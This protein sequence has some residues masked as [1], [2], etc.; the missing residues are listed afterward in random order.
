MTWLLPGAAAARKP[1]SQAVPLP[2]SGRCQQHKD[3]MHD[4]PVAG[5]ALDRLHPLVLFELVAHDEVLVRQRSPG[6]LTLN[7]LGIEYTASGVP[8][9]QP[10]R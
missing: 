2:V 5:A 1:R 4:R 9:F 3:M 7:G 8:M 10:A 6:P